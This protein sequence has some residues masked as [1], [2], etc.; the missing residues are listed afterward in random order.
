M[1]IFLKAIPLCLLL[2]APLLYGQEEQDIKI[3]SVSGNKA[4]VIIIA[5]RYNFE[6]SI[7]LRLKTDPALGPS[8][9]LIRTVSKFG[10]VDAKG[11]TIT[12]GFDIDLDNNLIVGFSGGTTEIIKVAGDPKAL[13]IIASFKD[14]GGNFINPPS[15]SVALYTLGGEKLCFDYKTINKDP[16]IAMTLLLDR[17][18]SM[19]GNIEEV[20]S[21][22]QNFLKLLPKNAA[23]AVASFNS[24]FF[25]AHKNY[26]A[27]G[28]G[29]FGFENITS[30]GGT[31]IYNAL[32]GAY[33]NMAQ[34]GFDGFQ[35]AV[36]IVTDGYTLS[37]A[38]KK[39]ALLTKKN[40]T[41]TFVYFIGGDK[42]D[43]L[44][45][46][47]DHF[48]AKNSDVKQSLTQY[49][50][51]IGQAYTSQKILRVKACGHK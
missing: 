15:D 37:D 48:F 7:S 24:D 2:N 31:D 50:G 30:S 14:E 17:S 23:C 42:K 26:Q 36:I 22:A 39:Q 12:S 27:C 28:G 34:K 51:A 32:S 9:A 1:K 49:F 25:Y 6:R 21:T 16:K 38:K 40:E 43:D 44:I 18:G 46:L 41:L 8:K 35:K 3:N 20:K 45:G 29:G 5:S 19:S 4:P 10:M 13:E 47:T 11:I 33:E